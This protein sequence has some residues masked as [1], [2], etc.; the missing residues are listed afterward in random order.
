MRAQ[1]PSDALAC[2]LD[3]NEDLSLLVLDG[4][5]LRRR[6]FP[7]DPDK[8]VPVQQRAFVSRS[9]SDASGEP[10]RVEVL[11]EGEWLELTDSLELELLERCLDGSASLDEMSA[12]LALETDGEVTH[13]D[14]VARMR[15]LYRLR[16][17]SFA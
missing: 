11:V 2:F 12:A 10:R 4:T 3:A 5:P 8:A 1:S 16:V 14:V 15:H 7:A 13:D 6:P 17:V 9:I